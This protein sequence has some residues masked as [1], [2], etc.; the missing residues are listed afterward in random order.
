MLNLV[1]AINY[2]KVT[3]QV[4]GAAALVAT[5]VKGTKVVDIVEAVKEDI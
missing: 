3:L 1:K 2:T 4:V 5:I